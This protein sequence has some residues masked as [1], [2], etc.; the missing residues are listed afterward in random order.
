[1]GAGRL[2]VAAHRSE[3]TAAERLG[4]A[5]HRQ[6]PGR[7][8]HL[9]SET[10]SERSLGARPPDAAEA[11]RVAP[12]AAPQGALRARPTPTL[13]L[14]RSGPRQGVR[15]DLPGASADLSRGPAPAPRPKVGERGRSGRRRVL[16][17]GPHALRRSYPEVLR[18]TLQLR[19]VYDPPQATDG[20]RYL[21]DRLWPRGLSAGALRLTAWRKELAP[22]TELRRSYC[23]DPALF[24]EFRRRYR[25][26]LLAQRAAL[27]ALVDEARQET[28][29]LLFAAKDVERSNAAVLGEMLEEL[30]A[31]KD[32]ART[33]PRTPRP[34]T[35]PARTG[36]APAPARAGSTARAPRRPLHGSRSR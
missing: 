19:R 35:G 1:M 2:A 28:V 30:G 21:V 31:P 5:L 23:H 15:E 18:L 26:E 33:S 34:G 20:H 17:S 3:P 8:D 25:N 11:V 22:S 27:A 29:T 4:G 9:P 14:A 13:A 32:P 6:H 16:K 36:S 24:P 10:P 12:N 7:R